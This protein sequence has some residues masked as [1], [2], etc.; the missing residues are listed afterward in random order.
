MA[1]PTPSSQPPEPAI[2]AEHRAR[3]VDPAE[4][5][6]LGRR[7]DAAELE[8]GGLRSAL[9][10]HE[11]RNE[12]IAAVLSDAADAARLAREELEREIAARHAAEAASVADR[13]GREAAERTLV[14]ERAAREAAQTALSA[15]RRR[16]ADHQAATTP[17]EPAHAPIPAPAA[18][19]PE[20]RAAPPQR[21]AS[22]DTDELLAG[23]AR[24]AE[25]LRAQAPL[26]PESAA[27]QV[28][29]PAVPPAVQWQ[30]VPVRGPRSGGLLGALERLLR[31]R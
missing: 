22:A 11:R 12:R 13:T 9:D 28:A 2:L 21:A 27:P 15:E 3:K 31:G 30:V 24:A 7:L 10:L 19:F 25:R 23:L 1:D 5:A 29:A 17:P 6:E 16:T 14:A 20:V 18:G 8:A 26:A 4:L